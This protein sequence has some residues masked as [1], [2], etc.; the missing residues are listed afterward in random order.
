MN[1]YIFK[2]NQCVSGHNFMHL[3]PRFFSVYEASAGLRSVYKRLSTVTVLMSS[4]ERL[5]RLSRT[6]LCGHWWRIHPRGVR[7]ILVGT[8]VKPNMTQFCQSSIMLL[9]LNFDNH[10]NE[11]WGIVQGVV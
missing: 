1:F 6:T 5:R 8:G 3:V 11:L 10:F 7:R 2:E 4:G 9:L